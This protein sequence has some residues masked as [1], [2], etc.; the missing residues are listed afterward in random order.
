MLKATEKRHCVPSCCRGG[1]AAVSVSILYWGGLMRRMRGS[2]RMKILLTQGAIR[3]VDG[4]RKCTFRTAIVTITER[5]TRINVNTRYLP[6]RR[7][8]TAFFNQED[9]SCKDLVINTCVLR[10]I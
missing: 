1:E 8:T 2:R 10:E 6:A 9:P 3:W 5:V 7:D 4:D